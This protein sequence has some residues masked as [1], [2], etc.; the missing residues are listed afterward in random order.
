MYG[1]LFFNLVPKYVMIVNNFKPRTRTEA[2]EVFSKPVSFGRLG[3][4]EEMQST[5]GKP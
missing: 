5:S 4:K 3:N 1:I 2:T